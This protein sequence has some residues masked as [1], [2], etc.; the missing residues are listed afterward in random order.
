M[1]LKL[2][3]NYGFEIFLISGRLSFIMAIFAILILFVP[4][5]FKYIPIFKNATRKTS[6]WMF[7]FSIILFFI[8]YLAIPEG[9][10]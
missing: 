2:F 3:G 1:D 6:I 7:L 4:K 9:M 8:S 10:P 5:L